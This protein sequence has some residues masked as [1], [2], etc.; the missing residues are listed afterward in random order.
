MTFIE[1]TTDYQRA[2]Y[3]LYKNSDDFRKDMAL[4][5]FLRTMLKFVKETNLKE[6]ERILEVYQN[7][8]KRT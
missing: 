3:Y 6:K 2:I 1:F 5:L 8:N 7:R 4:G